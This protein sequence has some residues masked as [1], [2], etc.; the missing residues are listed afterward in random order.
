MGKAINA[1]E[2]VRISKESGAFACKFQLFETAGHNIPLKP[3]IFRDMVGYGNSIGIEVFASVWD[4]KHLD[5][6]RRAGCKSVKF[7]YSAKDSNSIIIDALQDFDNIYISCGVLDEQL[8]N[9]ATYLYCIPEYP[10]PYKVAFDGI[11]ERFKGFSDHTLGIEQTKSAIDSGITLV[12]KHITLEK[13]KSKTPDGKF[14]ILPDELRAICSY[15]K[16][17]YNGCS[18]FR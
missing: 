17:M 15:K 14:A 3:E 18:C 12:E 4:M 2:L 16:G 8:W 5:I 11:A 10:V 9:K 1:Q 6:V 13:T 7:A